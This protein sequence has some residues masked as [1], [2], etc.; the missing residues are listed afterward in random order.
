ME[1]QIDPL[2]HSSYFEVCY[3]RCMYKLIMIV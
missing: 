3:L 2:K 1:L